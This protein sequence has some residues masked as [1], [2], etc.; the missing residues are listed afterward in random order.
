MN[1]DRRHRRK[2][3]PVN[4]GAW[5]E[6]IDQYDPYVEKLLQTHNSL[7]D[8]LDK[9]DEAK[10]IPQPKNSY[11]RFDISFFKGGEALHNPKVAH[12]NRWG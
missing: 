11:W 2:Y 3:G 6:A 1:K 5:E 9:T 4:T 12:G 7:E 8:T 10:Q